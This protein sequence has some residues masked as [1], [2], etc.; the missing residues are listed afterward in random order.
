MKG[1]GFILTHNLSDDT[2]G[3]YQFVGKSGASVDEDI[4]WLMVTYGRIA[5]GKAS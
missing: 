4:K 2:V 3:V 5:E 1:E